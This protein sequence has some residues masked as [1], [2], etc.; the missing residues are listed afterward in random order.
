MLYCGKP[1]KEKYKKTGENIKKHDLF[2][3]FYL[4]LSIFLSA[5]TSYTELTLKQVPAERLSGLNGDFNFV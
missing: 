3:Y 5:P 1:P 2:I 4:F